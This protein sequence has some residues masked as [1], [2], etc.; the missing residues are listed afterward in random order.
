MT[1]RR[2]AQ[3][4]KGRTGLKGQRGLRGRRGLQGATGESGPAG[5]RGPAG[6][7]ASRADILVA[8]SGQFAEINKRLETQLTRIAQLQRQLDAQHKE[9]EGVRDE[10]AQ[11]HRVLNQLLAMTG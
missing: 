2:E 9:T 1:A 3:G 5:A 4:P 6:E 7:P 8:V 10:L 11:V